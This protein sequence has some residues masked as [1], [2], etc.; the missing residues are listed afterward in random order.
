[1]SKS[2]SKEYIDLDGIKVKRYS[3][4]YP[5]FKQSTQCYLCGRQA[6][7][8]KVDIGYNNGVVTY[9]LN[10]YSDDILFTK[11]HVIPLSKGGANHI[12]NFKTCCTICNNLKGN[13]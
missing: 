11:D 2:F 8:F 1:M 5:V 6:T 10:L 7:H 9:H 13:R 4:R 3:R 12:S